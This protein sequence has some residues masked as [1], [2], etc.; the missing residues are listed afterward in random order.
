M[1]V[2]IRHWLSRNVIRLG[3]AALF[4]EILDK[5]YFQLGISFLAKAAIEY[6]WTFAM[7][8]WVGHVSTALDIAATIASSLFTFGFL[9]RLLDLLEKRQ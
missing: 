2:F 5:L 4:I 1:R 9:F 3:I 8:D 6:E 7:S